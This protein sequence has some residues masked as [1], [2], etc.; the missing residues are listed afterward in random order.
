VS[1][2]IDAEAAI[3]SLLTTDEHL[4]EELRSAILGHGPDVVPALLAILEDEDLRYEEPPDGSWAPNHAAALLGELRAV[5]AIAPMLRILAATDPYESIHDAVMEALAAM[6]D[7]AVEPLLQAHAEWSEP[8]LRADVASVLAST[9]VRDDR[10]LAALIDA[11]PHDPEGIG[12]DLAK[13]GDA[14]ALPALGRAFDEYEY[15][16]DDAP[17]AAQVLGDLQ[18]AIEALGGSLTASQVKQL[19]HAKGLIERLRDEWRAAAASIEP[20]RRVLRPG[21]NEACWCGSGSKYKK[22]H[23]ASDDDG[24]TAP[25]AQA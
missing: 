10:I 22:C 21:R 5:D 19:D 1:P 23:L 3:Q 20:A 2:P 18:Q 25:P 7:V 8:D 4:P 16:Y 13:Y 6:G 9:G 17:V 24:S 15:E 14:K 12:F 11:L